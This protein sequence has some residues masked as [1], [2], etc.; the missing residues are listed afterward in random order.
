L[1]TILLHLEFSV[2]SSFSLL[3]S[4]LR[5]VHYLLASSVFI[6]NLASFLPFSPVCNISLFGQSPL[7]T[8]CLKLGV[9]EHIYNPNTQVAE[10]GRS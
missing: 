4:I 9:M 2:D 6:E 1:K 10:V 7:G 3:F 5:G 8:I